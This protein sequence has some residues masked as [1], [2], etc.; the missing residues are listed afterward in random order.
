MLSVLRVINILFDVRGYVSSPGTCSGDSGG[1]AFVREGN[2]FVLTG[3]NNF[4]TDIGK[5]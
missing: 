4:E 5:L 1:P 3:I 2:K